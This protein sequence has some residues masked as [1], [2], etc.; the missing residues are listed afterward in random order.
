[1]KAGVYRVSSSRRGA[2]ARR[3]LEPCAD[4]HGHGHGCGLVPWRER[5]T[6]AT[7]LC[8]WQ[9]RLRVWSLGAGLSL[10]YNTQSWDAL[11]VWRSGQLRL[12]LI[13]TKHNIRSVVLPFLKMK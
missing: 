11:L 4:G 7:K 2:A 8:S 5:S 9:E 13:E 3:G 6:V 10:E 1:M 12:H